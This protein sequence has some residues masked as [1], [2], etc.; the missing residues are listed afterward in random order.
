MKRTYNYL[1]AI[2][3]L[4]AFTS[5][6]YAQ[7]KGK[8]PANILI[9]I[10][11]DMS[12]TAGAYG[13]HTIST[14]GIDSLAKDGV[15]FKNSYCTASSC[16]PSR[17]SILTG[18]FPHQLAEGGNLWGFLP[19]S[20]PNYTKILAE[21]GY[22]I[23]LEGKGWGPGNFKA[24]GYENNP[25]GPTGKTF[26]QFMSE[27]KD[28]EPFCFWIGSLDPHRTYDPELK[29]GVKFN[30]NALKVPS[31]LPDNEVVRNDLKDYYAE[32][33][34][35]DETIQKAIAL[36]KEKGLYD[37]TLI[38]VTSDNGMPFPRAKANNYEVST[39]IPLVIRWGKQFTNGKAT[40]ALVSLVDLAPTI[41]QAAEATIP[42]QM[43]GKSL[44]PLLTTGKT[45]ERFNV[46]FTERERHARV[47]EHNIGYPVRAVRTRDFLY[48]NNIMADR[49]PAGDPEST[50]R[51][52]AYGDIDPGPTKKFIVDHQNDPAL[53]NIV[54]W[55]LAKRPAIELY[56]L[57]KDPHQL[58]N[59]A[60]DL[61]YAKIENDLK[62][63][64]DNWRKQTAD[65]LVNNKNDIFDTYPYYGE[66]E[67][68]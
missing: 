50:Q 41:L 47:R 2:C 36:L 13:D 10:A 11:D 39:K 38:I 61:K 28:G 24:A 15:L 35:F 16:S 32:V 7:Q 25:A 6:S 23:G 20:Y 51:N 31:W 53:K 68:L 57:K 3:C 37:Q 59:L 8:S 34:R 9:I 42:K 55:S 54:F 22:R 33:K 5:I 19:V 14:P 43:T 63:K 40:D 49:W 18:R 58:K 62:A 67:K 21:K 46:V 45:E 17:A 66:K 4:V 26:E 27:Q 60:G 29:N 44:L 30:E 56:D 65:P 64:L 12:P 52:G 1:L 48:I